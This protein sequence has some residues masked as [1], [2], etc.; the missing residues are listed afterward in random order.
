M[1]SPPLPAHGGSGA[2]FS[3]L[4]GTH[5]GGGDVPAIATAARDEIGGSL[6]SSHGKVSLA[7]VAQKVP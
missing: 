4:G 1:T 3:A 2:A 6:P 7:R 5:G